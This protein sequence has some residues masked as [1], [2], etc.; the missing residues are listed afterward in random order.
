MRQLKHHEAKLLKRYV[1]CVLRVLFAD[2]VHRA[3][4]YT[5]LFFGGTA[6]TTS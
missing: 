4:A 5:I 1:L 6:V 2:I 3:L